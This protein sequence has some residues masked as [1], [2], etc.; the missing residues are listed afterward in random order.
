MMPQSDIIVYPSAATSVANLP[1]SIHSRTSDPNPGS[2]DLRYQSE[3]SLGMLDRIETVPASVIASNTLATL[4]Q[5]EYYEWIAGCR[6]WF[7]LD[8]ILKFSVYSPQQNLHH[9]FIYFE[10]CFYIAERIETRSKWR[11]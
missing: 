8:F 2:T 11:H 7:H 1:P 6:N 4:Q 5:I 10:H 3:F 9:V